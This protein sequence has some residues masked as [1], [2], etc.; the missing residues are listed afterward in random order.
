M[1][2]PESTQ[3]NPNVA[4]AEA[5]AKSVWAWSQAHTVVATALLA[6][7]AGFIVGKIL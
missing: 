2:D 5:A 6:F 7:V 4:K 1:S 3:P